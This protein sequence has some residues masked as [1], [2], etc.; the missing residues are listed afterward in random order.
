MLHDA[1]GALI[2]R[3]A[4]EIELLEPLGARFGDAARAALE[5]GRTAGMS[6]LSDAGFGA[7]NLRDQASKL[8]SQ[9]LGAAGSAGS[10]ALG[11]ARDAAAK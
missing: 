8:V 11:A 6:A 10:A 1:C 5:A 2:P 9:A 7:D 4:K 3:A